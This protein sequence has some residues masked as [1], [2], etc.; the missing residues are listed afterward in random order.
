MNINSIK[1]KIPKVSDRY[2]WSIY[3]WVKTNGTNF[4]VLL[5][6]SE[7]E[8]LTRRLY[9]I[10]NEGGRGTVG[11]NV[12]SIMSG[13][14]TLYCF[15]LYPLHKYPDVTEWFWINYL[16]FGRCM[17]DPGHSKYFLGDDERYTMINKNSK[18]CNWC[19]KYLKR[20]IRKQVS[21]ERVEHW[22]G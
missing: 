19:G 22:E 4:R 1:P 2:S 18:R 21:I 16:R 8:I 11:S 9:F 10:R 5:D 15:S 17:V 3:Q 20:N 7:D 6:P 13:Q 12:H 14:R